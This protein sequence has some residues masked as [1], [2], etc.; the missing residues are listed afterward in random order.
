[1]AH[2]RPSTY[3]VACSSRATTASGGS[4]PSHDRVGERPDERL[5]LGLVD[6]VELVEHDDLRPLGEAAA[7]LRELAVDRGVAPAAVR[8]RVA[9]LGIDGD[10]VHE[11]EGALEVREERVAEP[12]AVGGA[13]EQPRDVGDG[14]LPQVVELDRAELRRERRE[15][16]VGDLGRG[17]RDAPQ[18]RRL[19]GVREAEQRGVADHLEAQLELGRLALLADLGG[20]RRLARRPW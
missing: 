19:A 9:G 7:V 20:A 11:R 2:E 12:D 16:V 18:Q 17:V 5:A 10:D 4:S 15:R 13:L 6:Q 8:E 1:M 3:G 14:E